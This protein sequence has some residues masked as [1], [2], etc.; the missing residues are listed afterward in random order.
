MRTINDMKP[1]DKANVVK[2]HGTGA[3][4]KRV[5]DMGLTKGASVTL[6]KRAPLGDPIEIKVREYGLSL[7]NTEA[8]IVE[9]E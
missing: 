8:M 1:G 4:R 7:R 9:I 3:V 5:L 2:V 6:I